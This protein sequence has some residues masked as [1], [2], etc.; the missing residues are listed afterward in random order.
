MRE[1]MDRVVIERPR[2]NR[3]GAQNRKRAERS[4]MKRMG[5]DAPTKATMSP[6]RRFGYDCKNLADLINPLYRW[7]DKQVGRPWDKVWSEV[8]QTLK[9]GT[10]S[11]DHIKGHVESGV[12]QN[13]NIK[14]IDGF[15]HYVN[16]FHNPALPLNAGDRY[17]DDKGFL[18][19]VPRI[20]ANTSRGRYKSEVRAPPYV[21]KDGKFYKEIEGIWFELTMVPYVG[22]WLTFS[23]EHN[24][25]GLWANY[26]NQYTI[27]DKQFY[28]TNKRTLSRK[29]KRALLEGP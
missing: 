16:Q 18:R 24:L 5:E 29:E 22:P 25:P 27:R 19:M 17:V 11:L 20:K 3:S 6:G 23:Q 8:C 13:H 9:G 15:P 2:T 12:T 10:T 28:C 4:S 21:E 26:A 14:M 1:D 7:L